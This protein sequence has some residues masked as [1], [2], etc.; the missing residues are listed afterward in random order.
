PA[1]PPNPAGVAGRL[2]PI[3]NPFTGTPLGVVG[4]VVGVPHLKLSSRDDVDVGVVVAAFQPEPVELNG[5]RSVRLLLDELGF[6]H[7]VLFR[8]GGSRLWFL[9]RIC[10]DAREVRMAPAVA[11]LP[12]RDRG[13][14]QRRASET[15]N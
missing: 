12:E 5:D 2:K 15:D 3:R 9:E 1:L 11:V 4:T 7:Q 6:A 8:G 10:P 14:K 13:C